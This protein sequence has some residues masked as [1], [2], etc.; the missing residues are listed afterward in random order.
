VVCLTGLRLYGHARKTP[1]RGAGSGAVLLTASSYGGDA[2]NPLVMFKAGA[3]TVE[4]EGPFGG[5]SEPNSVY[6][7]WEA[8][9]REIYA[10]LG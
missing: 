2:T 6:K 10:H 4:I 8:L 5:L 9:A 1:F 7:K 3:Y